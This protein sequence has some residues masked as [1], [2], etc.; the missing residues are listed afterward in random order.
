VEMS[1]LQIQ[2]KRYSDPYAVLLIDPHDEDAWRQIFGHHLDTRVCTVIAK[3]RWENNL[4][5]SYSKNYRE[6]EDYQRE[7]LAYC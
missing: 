3:E 6:T 1:Q 7:V 5:G 2:R 4:Y